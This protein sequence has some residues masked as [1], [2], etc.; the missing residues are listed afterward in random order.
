MA[1]FHR[2]VGG[3]D[4]N[5]ISIDGD[6]DAMIA[7]ALAA[8]EAEEEE[9][10]E[11]RLLFRYPMDAN[12][13]D[14]VPISNMDKRRLNKKVREYKGTQSIML[15][16]VVV[17]HGCVSSLSTP[18]QYSHAHEPPPHCTHFYTPMTHELASS[19]PFG[20]EFLNDNLIDFYFKLR[21]KEP[22]KVGGKP[23]STAHIF[24]THFYTKLTEEAPQPKSGPAAHL[25]EAAR[26]HRKVRRW[27]KG[28]DVFEKDFVFVPINMSLHW[29]LAVICYPGARSR[30]R[31]PRTDA[32]C[33]APPGL[34]FMPPIW[35]LSLRSSANATPRTSNESDAV[36]CRPT[37][38]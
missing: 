27:T 20:Q 29:S 11:E 22:D 9:E 10:E 3:D 28:F 6:D 15:V 16:K 21:L 34:V 26:R 12:A 36:M 33:A 8:A 32:V 37:V 17:Y 24:S 35:Q 18:V 30:Y 23:V 38:R 2:Q 25:D 7:R 13:A 19:Y 5:P 14:P 31:T 4:A 1:E